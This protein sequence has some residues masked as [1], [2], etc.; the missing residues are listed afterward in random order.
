MK[1]FFAFLLLLGCCLAGSRA[2]AQDVIIL[3]NGD[4]IQAKVSVVGTEAV[5]YKKWDN[6]NGPDY[7]QQ[8]SEIFMI[9]YANGSKDVFSAKDA[10]MTNDFVGT[11]QDA[12]VIASNPVTSTITDGRDGK[13]YKTVTLG[14]Q[15]WLAENLNYEMPG[16]WCID[17]NIYG[18]SYTYEASK[19]A[20]PSGWHLPSEAEWT[21][22]TDFAGGGS[23]VGGYL[24]EAGTLHWKSP[25]T[26]ATNSSGF[27][28]LP[29]GF[30]TLLGYLS[31]PTKFAMFWT[32]TESIFPNIKSFRLDYNKSTVLIVESDRNIGNSIRCIKD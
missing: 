19:K 24:K 28:A 18:R 29:H 27:T 17:C 15:T 32:S 21:K 16:S 10:K 3:K 26:G 31:E 13:T 23:V 22:L 11:L 4:E 9:K 8:K 2:F 7:N 20:C 25:N 14:R 30:R 5:T 6:L 12:N 1:P